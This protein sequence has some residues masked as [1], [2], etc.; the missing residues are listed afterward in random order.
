MESGSNYVR[1]SR[2]PGGH[3]LPDSI[4]ELKVEQACSFDIFLGKLAQF[5]GNFELL[6][7]GHDIS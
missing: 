5:L 3:G 2:R 1:R 4:H 6:I 7:L